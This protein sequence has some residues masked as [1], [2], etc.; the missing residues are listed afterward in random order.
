MHV[1][2][3]GSTGFVGTGVIKEL[4]AAGHTVTG[5]CRSEKSAEAIRSPNVT[6][7][8]GTLA[9]TDVLRKAASEADAVI[10]L[11]FDL[12]VGFAKACEA[13]QAAIRALG[14]SLVSSAAAA[15]QEG[16]KG[17]EKV[18]VITS[19][20]ALLK[21]GTLVDEDSEKDLSHP[22]AAA[23]GACEDL[24]HSFAKP[25]VLRTCVVRLPPTVHGP[26][27]CGF[28]GVLAR[29][30]LQKGFSAYPTTSSPAGQESNRWCA[31]HRDDAAKVYVLAL[32]APS[33]STFHAVAEEA[34]SVKDA[35]TEIGR[36]LDVPVKALA[37]A[38]EVA[39][40]FGWFH[41]VVVVDNVASSEK[42]RERL[43][44]KPTGKT[45]L[46]DVPLA[47]EFAKSGGLDGALTK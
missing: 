47:I 17:K 5:L 11:A 7:L 26:G 18:L 41:V 37:T 32:G 44:W 23:R 36:L 33:G 39:G 34:V 12:G 27:N 46:E 22:V 8:I 10:H 28:I 13:D 24:A 31:V 29:T 40:H 35:A 2:V 30:A 43:G 42:T 4:L 38:E 14:E 15:A 6:P 9:D 45:A 21:S 25:G 20:T 16:G 19:G 3:T 1:F